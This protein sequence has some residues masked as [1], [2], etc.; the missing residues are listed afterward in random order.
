M[1][2][3]R[4]IGG[5]GNEMFQYAAGRALA[6]RHGTDLKL[7]M[8]PFQTYHLHRYALQHFDIQAQ[9]ATAADLKRVTRWQGRKRRAI[10]AAMKWVPVRA[11]R[12][13]GYVKEN[14]HSFNATLL[15]APDDVYLEG[16]W[17]TE[18]YFSD[19]ES[20]IRSDFTQTTPRDPLNKEYASKIKAQAMSVSLHV[21][22]G[23]YANDA[24]TTAV[25]GLC[26][27]AYYQRCLALLK[28]KVAQAHVFVFSDDIAWARQALTFDG[29][30]TYVGH[31]GPDK[32]YDDLALMSLCHH[33]I[34]GNSTFSWWGAWLNP[35]PNK[36]VYAP[37]PFFTQ[38]DRDGSDLIPRFWT[39]VARAA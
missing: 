14:G 27:P 25:H 17:Q 26:S 11:W 7:D 15:D 31:K 9:P 6:Q 33:H 30:V 16:Y 32:N 38:S 3:V 12:P 36:L 4:L 23:D 5:L 1:I 21:R 22:R 29:P 18:R 19:I 34:I 10:N 24:R 2:V 28:A 13:L 37:K 20:I 39:T 35:G 8:T